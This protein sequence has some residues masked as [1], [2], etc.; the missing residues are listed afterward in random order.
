MCVFACDA[1]VLSHRH[2]RIRGSL[3]SSPSESVDYVKKQ[4][5]KVMMA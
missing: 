5:K 1:R 3:K 2:A 4:L